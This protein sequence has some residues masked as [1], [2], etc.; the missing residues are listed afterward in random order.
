MSSQARILTRRLGPGPEPHLVLRALADRP[1]AFLLESALRGGAGRARWSY[2]GAEPFLTLA[3]KG[4][5]TWTARDGD[6]TG[7]GGTAFNELRPL[8]DGFRA[9][10]PSAEDAPEFLAGAVGYFGYEL[11][12]LI[13]K[14]PGRVPD[15][16]GLP[17]MHLGFY[18]CVLAFDHRAGV[19]HAS[20]VDFDGGSPEVRIESAAALLAAPAVAAAGG[21]EQGA[22][23]AESLRSNFSAPEY[24]AA[25]ARVIEY[26][27]AGDIFQASFTQRFTADWP[28]GAL[29][30]YERLRAVNP[31]PFA[32]YYDFGEGQVV[33]ASP[34]LFL[35]VAGR[36]VETRPIKGTRPR[37][38]AP[39]EDRHLAAELQ[40][41]PKDRAEL[42]M[43]VDLER[44][45]LGRVCSYG[46]VRVAGHLELESYP[47]VHHLASTVVGELHE[48]RDLVD[49]LKAA[50][51]GGSITG[52]PKVRAMEI[53]DELERS[54]RGVYTG[55]VGFIGFE[56]T[57]ELNLPI[58]TFTV[59]DGRAH[60]GVGGGVVADST[61]AG[62]Y[63]E[64]LDKA[65]GLI[66]A[67]E[68]APVG[69][70]VR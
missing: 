65:R 30:L 68:R 34:E 67:L 63:Q 33:S 22:S 36:R 58:R 62:E 66:A 1:G 61:P 27:R 55:A 9:A 2:L 7:L 57:T 25:V 49:L 38:S 24:E 50:F 54:A 69:E 43:I 14:L 20:A 46:S 70:V 4:H 31:A 41:S 17:D 37:G 19:W 40:A 16:L 47:T 11:G 23:A 48:D 32:G 26:I 29:D 52:A 56:G 60:F 28:R 35:H 8:L 3:A 10:R 15:E 51:P 6:R 42:T 5:E 21:S 18:D 13:E 44:N 45:D 12:R 39:D 64:S 59:A 53:I